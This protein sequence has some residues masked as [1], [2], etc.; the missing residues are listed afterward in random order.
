MYIGP[1]ECRPLR[2]TVEVKAN[3]DSAALVIQKAAIIGIAAGECFV[4]AQLKY[5]DLALHDEIKSKRVPIPGRKNFEPP[6]FA[7]G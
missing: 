3:F 2:F 1:I 4:S 7:I 6:G 5:A